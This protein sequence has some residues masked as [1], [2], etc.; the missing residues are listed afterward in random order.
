MLVDVLPSAGSPW[1]PSLNNK[2]AVVIDVFR[3]TSTMVTAFANGCRMIIP[4]LTTEEA[5]ER[6]NSEPGCLL[7]GERKALPIKGFDV[8]NSPF[9]Y[10]PEKVRNKTLVMTTTNGTR[11]IHA[12]IEARQVWIAAFLNA[13]FVAD[14]ICEYIKDNPGIEGVVIICAGSE[15]R[16][17]IPDTLC[18]GMLVDLLGEGIEMNDLGRAAK[19]LYNISE[20]K[21]LDMLITTEHGQLLKSIGCERDVVYCSQTNILPITPV[22]ENG[23]VIHNTL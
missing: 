7:G 13:R 8:G 15:D 11:A 16:F 21:I 5:L 17:D 10:T 12:V 3:A 14:A 22:L 4:V 6:R 20:K 18:A 23:V 19:L 2:V 1:I 9:E